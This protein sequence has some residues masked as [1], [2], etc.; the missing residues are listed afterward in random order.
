MP[1]EGLEKP[2]DAGMLK[3]ML[4]IMAEVD[5]RGNPRTNHGLDKLLNL[6]T[7]RMKKAGKI[8]MPFNVAQLQFV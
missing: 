2:A 5:I 8:E 6:V 7:Q 3:D 4:D 1:T